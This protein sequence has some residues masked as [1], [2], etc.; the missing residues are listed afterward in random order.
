MYGR[1]LISQG[2]LIVA[3]IPKQTK[4]REK[5]RKK[6]LIQ[7]SQ[8]MC[9]VSIVMYHMACVTCL[10]SAD[11]KYANISVTTYHQ[12]SPVH[13]LAAFPQLHSHTDK[14]VANNLVF[15]KDILYKYKNECYYGHLVSR[16]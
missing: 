7:M 1:H 4:A 3:T 5:K 12:K 14:S 9:Q 10:L 6:I 15:A 16:K 13:K 8:D 11:P 2:V